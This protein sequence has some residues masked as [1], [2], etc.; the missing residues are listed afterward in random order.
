M[1]IKTTHTTDNLLY[2]PVTINMTGKT[3][4]KR[5]NT[6]ERNTKM[7]TVPIIPIYWV[8]LT[9]GKN[10]NTL[11]FHIRQ[12]A[13][14]ASSVVCPSKRTEKKEQDKKGQ[15]KYLASAALQAVTIV[16]PHVE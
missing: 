15:G 13:A 14:Q 3:T 9:K 10:N 2:A 11:Q 8:F 6:L 5:S 1:K 4:K 16:V 7:V 12:L